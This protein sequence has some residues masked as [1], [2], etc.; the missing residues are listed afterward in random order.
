M[1]VYIAK[2]SDATDKK[3]ISFVKG[4][5]LPTGGIIIESEDSIYQ[6]YKSEKEV[7]ELGQN[8]M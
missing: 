5:D 7:L 2:I 8:G 6:T 4:P 3:I 1:L